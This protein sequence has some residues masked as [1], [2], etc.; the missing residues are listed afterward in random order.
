MNA[1]IFDTETT[2]LPKHPRAKMTVQPR[3]IEFGAVL[4]DECGAVCG[5]LNLLANPGEKLEA[6]ITKITGLT[7]EDLA[8]EPPF[9]EILPEIRA[10]FE[11]ADMMIA[12]NLPFDAYL[13]ELELQRLG[14]DDFPWPKFS[15]CTVQENFEEYGYRPKM[16]ELYEDTLGV[17]LHQTHRASDD[18]NALAEI[19]KE[20]NYVQRYYAATQGA[21]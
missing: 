12:H 11:R 16:L 2:G 4:V 17:P 15:I 5:E 18:C 21:K 6:I 10:F 14:I 13:L 20:K 1:I 3:I 19:V 8:V 9:R 7:D